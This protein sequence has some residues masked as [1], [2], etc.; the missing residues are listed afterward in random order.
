MNK[1][2]ITGA[3][4]FIGFHLALHYLKKGIHVVAID[5]M[6]D[7]YDVNLK[8]NRIKI[9]E[10]YANFDF[11]QEDLVNK[12]ALLDIFKKY[13]FDFVI[14]LAAQAGV[15]YSLTN[16]DVYIN[17]NIIGFINLLECMKNVNAK[18]LIYASSSSVYGLSEIFP[19]KED[20][21]T[22][23]PISLYGGTK[24][25]N[26]VLAHS[27][28]HLYKMNIIGLRFFTVYGPMGRPD[29]ALFLFT[30][31]ILENKT[32]ELFNYGD[33]SR[34]FTY[35]DD[36]INS[37]S[38]LSTKHYKPKDKPIN[39]I[40]NIGGHESVNLKDFVKVIEKSLNK[41]AKIEFKPM[42][43]GDVKDTIA[44]NKLLFEEIDYKPK[45]TFEEGAKKFIEWYQEYYSN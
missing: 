8:K 36:I 27:Y 15:R 6:N 25:S 35:I 19:L 44:D 26:E 22:N 38:L 37:I 14:N 40:F 7:Y 41:K 17:S 12:E 39:K 31:K 2:F 3:G 33:H 16:P 34:S 9:L 10:Q 28:H 42:Q 24:K 18:N 30:K 11:Y 29:M 32:I 13:K 43:K 21:N 1:V 5:N 20:L 45:T 23:N 4:G